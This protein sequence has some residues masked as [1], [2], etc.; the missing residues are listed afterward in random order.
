MCATGKQTFDAVLHSVDTYRPTTWDDH[1]DL[2]RQSNLFA[3][4]VAADV[5]ELFD[6]M[7]RTGTKLNDTELEALLSPTHAPLLLATA[8]WQKYPHPL[9]GWFLQQT[10]D[11][12]SG[13][14]NGHTDN[15]HEI[16]QTLIQIGKRLYGDQCKTAANIH[17]DDMDAL[18]RSKWHQTVQSAAETA[19]GWKSQLP[20]APRRAVETLLDALL[21]WEH[22]PDRDSEL[23]DW[24]MAQADHSAADQRHVPIGWTIAAQGAAWA[25]TWYAQRG[26]VWDWHNNP[27]AVALSTHPDPWVRQR[28]VQTLLAPRTGGWLDRRASHG[29]NVSCNLPSVRY[30]APYW[31]QLVQWWG[32]HEPGGFGEAYQRMHKDPDKYIR[33]WLRDMRIWLRLAEWDRP[34][35]QHLDGTSPIPWGTPVSKPHG[36]WTD[37]DVALLTD[38]ELHDNVIWPSLPSRP[39]DDLPSRIGADIPV[40]PLPHDTTRT[41]IAETT[42]TKKPQTLGHRVIRSDWIDRPAHCKQLLAHSD[43]QVRAAALCLGKPTQAQIQKMCSDKASAVRHEAARQLVAAL[44]HQALRDNT[45]GNWS[46]VRRTAPI[47]L[48]AL[49]YDPNETVFDAARRYSNLPWLDMTLDETDITPH[50]G[51]DLWRTNRFVRRAAAILTKDPVLLARLAGDRSPAVAGPLTHRDDLPTSI[52]LR[53]AGHPSRTIRDAAHRQLATH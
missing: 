31:Q 22:R 17:G 37:A 19:L 46:P 18:D 15:C 34:L 2:D 51:T 7:V 41:L 49:L 53:L 28:F 23:S 35:R 39:H 48:A 13:H 3:S 10:L 36:T 8:F 26:E 21:R 24:M 4:G 30:H 14:C 44:Q 40:D 12:H 45:P 16:Q 27:Y 11:H 25:A 20:P 52:W 29:A 9:P 32:Y 47:E 42:K 43:P 5:P 38:P 6:R 50:V 1:R 33:T